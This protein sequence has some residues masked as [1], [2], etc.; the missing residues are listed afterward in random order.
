MCV[1]VLTFIDFFCTLEQVGYNL[2]L[3]PYKV[4]SHPCSCIDVVKGNF[5]SVLGAG[6]LV[7]LDPLL[8]LL[9]LNFATFR[10]VSTHLVTIK[11]D[12][13]VYS[14]NFDAI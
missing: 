12:E 4:L 6:C 14:M 1:V 5:I 2:W 13:V 10:A 9:F 8:N 11:V 3:A 7:L